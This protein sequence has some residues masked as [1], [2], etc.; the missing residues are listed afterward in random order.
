MLRLGFEK[1][2]LALNNSEIK[3]DKVRKKT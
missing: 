1:Y 2:Q 3:D